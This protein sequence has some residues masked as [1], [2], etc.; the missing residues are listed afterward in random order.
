MPLHFRSV[1]TPT[2]RYSVLLKIVEGIEQPVTERR[3]DG[4]L[5]DLAQ[6]VDR[7]PELLQIVLAAVAFQ[8]VRI[9]RARVSV[10]SDPSR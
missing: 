9:N 8:Q 5:I 2:E 1:R 10:S 7:G 6:G 4:L 3:I